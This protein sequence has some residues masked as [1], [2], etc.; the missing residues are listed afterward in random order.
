M[1]RGASQQTLHEIRLQIQNANE[2]NRLMI[3]DT[4]EEIGTEEAFDLL[5]QMLPDRS[6]RVQQ[7]LLSILTR[8]EPRAL[9]AMQR[10]LTHPSPAHQRAALEIIKMKPWRYGEAL[11]AYIHAALMNL[12]PTPDDVAAEVAALLEQIATDEAQIAVARWRAAHPQPGTHSVG[13]TVEAEPAAEAQ[14]AA[15]PMLALVLLDQPRPDL[16]NYPQA[17]AALLQ[18]IR[19]GQWGDQQEAVNALHRLAA[20]LQDAAPYEVMALLMDALDDT[21]A[22]VRWAGAEALGRMRAQAAVERLG[23]RVS[24]PVWTVQVAAIRALMEIGDTAALYWVEPALDEPNAGV[25]EAAVEALGCLG[26]ARHVERL[27]AIMLSGRDP[28]VRIAAVEAARGLRA[29]GVSEAL[30]ALLDEP[31]LML[32]WAAARALSELADISAVP[33]LR[34]HLHDTGQPAW[35]ERRVCDFIQAALERIQASKRA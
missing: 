5:A 6:A 3:V 33:A 4:L 17:V 34:A 10:L 19:T 23:Q 32:R 15:A 9:R 27:K 24:D 1:T 21:N 7:T 29:A 18:H 31:L 35:E 28:M 16:V 2:A 12:I 26:S 13:E 20:D 30:T 14:P 11:C 25:Q 8:T 22:M